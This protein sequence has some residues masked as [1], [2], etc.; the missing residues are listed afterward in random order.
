MNFNHTMLNN[1]FILIYETR[2]ILGTRAEK[3]VYRHVPE[4]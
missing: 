3:Q 1:N 2:F 4:L